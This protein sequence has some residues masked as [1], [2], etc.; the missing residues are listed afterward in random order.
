MIDCQKLKTIVAQQ[1]VIHIVATSQSQTQTIKLLV[2]S[3][4]VKGINVQNVRHLFKHKE[5]M[6]MNRNHTRMYSIEVETE[7]IVVDITKEVTEVKVEEQVFL[8]ARKS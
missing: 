6:K 5:A 4:G 8:V 2:I 7:V 1:V 3:V